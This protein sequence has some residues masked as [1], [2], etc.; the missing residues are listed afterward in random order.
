[1]HKQMID[2]E[3]DLSNQILPKGDTVPS[4]SR[5]E[6]VPE[7]IGLFKVCVG[8]VWTFQS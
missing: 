2:A 4:L 1:M 3:C 8:G 6:N 7:T 5:G